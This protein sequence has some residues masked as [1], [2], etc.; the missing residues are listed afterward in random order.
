M[1]RNSRKRPTFLPGHPALSAW[2]SVL[3]NKAADKTQSLFQRHLTELG[4]EIRHYGI[5]FL[6]GQ[7]GPLSQIELGQQLQIDRALM[8]QCIDHLE[9]RQW[10]KRAPN[11][12]D[13][14]SHAITLTTEG[15]TI[16]AQATAQAEAVEAEFLSPLSERE[17]QQLHRLLTRLLE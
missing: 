3:L 2:T 16:L 1:P 17:R 10:V 8:V 12:S 6:I 14:R 13:R 5:L 11:P 15:Q 9:S 7:Q 4:I